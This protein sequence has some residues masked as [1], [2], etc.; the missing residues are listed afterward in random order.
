M[1][2]NTQ[3]NARNEKWK[4]EKWRKGMGRGRGT[5]GSVTVNGTKRNESQEMSQNTKNN[6]R[7][8]GGTTSNLQPPTCTV[9]RVLRTKMTIHQVLQQFA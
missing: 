5:S 6:K 2:H 7:F 8:A 4:G 3:Q 1:R 9:K